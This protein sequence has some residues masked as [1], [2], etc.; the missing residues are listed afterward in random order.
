MK[1]PIQRSIHPSD[2]PA[3]HGV[4]W[5]W[6]MHGL[7]NVY[8]L[9]AASILEKA[10][11]KRH[12]SF[13][14]LSSSSCGLP[15]VVDFSR[16][17]QTNTNTGFERDVR[18][19]NVTSMPVVSSTRQTATN[20]G[21]SSV[22]GPSSSVAAS[23]LA[24]ATRTRLSTRQS[25]AA[26][27]SIG[28]RIRLFLRFVQSSAVAKMVVDGSSVIP[29]FF[30]SPIVFMS[31]FKLDSIHPPCSWSSSFSVSFYVHYLPA[32]MYQWSSRNMPKPLQ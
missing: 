9:E 18:R 21:L 27:N 32:G 11:K 13:V 24:S 29:R 31:L 8:D 28:Y 10:Y 7:W 20:T 25:S 16:W 15:Y 4:S 1:T 19:V 3:A 17:R 23:H 26:S 30:P 14:D 12:N 5:Q 6:S 2:S 22:A